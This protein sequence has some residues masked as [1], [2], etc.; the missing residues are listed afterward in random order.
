MEW[1][2]QTGCDLSV[3]GAEYQEFITMFYLFLYMFGIFCNETFLKC[4]PN[5]KY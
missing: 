2:E 3:V 4:F 1:M 5:S